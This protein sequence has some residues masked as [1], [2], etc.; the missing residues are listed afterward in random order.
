VASVEVSVARYELSVDASDTVRAVLESADMA[1]GQSLA[2]ALLMGSCQ[3]DV[4]IVAPSAPV[5]AEDFRPGQTPDTRPESVAAATV[6]GVLSV[7]ADGGYLESYDVWAET[8]SQAYLS[9]GRVLA[10]VRVLRP[11]TLLSVVYRW[12]SSG[13]LGPADQ[14][15][16]TD[17]TSTVEAGWY[18]VG[19]TGDV[20]GHLV[21]AAGVDVEGS[22]D[23]RDT[24][25]R[26]TDWAV[27][28]EG[29]LASHCAAGCD[30]CRAAWYAES[31]TWHFTP[32]HGSTA[33]DGWDFDDVED[34]DDRGMIACPACRTGRVGF[35]IY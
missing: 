11:F 28:V 21:G 27:N 3:P 25:G 20:T 9:E 17:R 29:F 26:L 19:L 2:D 16:I 31:G 4:F 23:P 15:E 13:L 24:A 34:V 14:W 12:S 33:V 7:L 10:A 30:R 22:D 1:R 32:E 18:L 8:S 35:S 5:R 6:D